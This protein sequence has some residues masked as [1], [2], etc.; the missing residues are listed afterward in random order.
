MVYGGR[1]S[2]AC[3]LFPP[4]SPAM[5]R[6]PGTQPPLRRGLSVPWRLLLS[7]LA[8]TGAGGALGVVGST[9]TTFLQVVALGAGVLLAAGGV[10]R[11]FREAGWSLEERIETSALV[12]LAGFAALL[13]YFGADK[14]W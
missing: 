4:R 12:S 5:A 2:G 11:R 1:A 7:G 6:D 14:D 13:A 8:V 3:R 10:A 9:L